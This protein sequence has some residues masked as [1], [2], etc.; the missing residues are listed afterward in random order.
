[1]KI[2]AKYAGQWV[3]IKSEKVVASGKTFE[4]LNKKTEKMTGN[5]KFRYTLLPKGLFAGAL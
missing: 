5:K 2:E 3:A 4:I 1:M